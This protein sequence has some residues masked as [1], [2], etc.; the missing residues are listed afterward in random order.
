MLIQ[1]RIQENAALVEAALDSF[2]TA[3]ADTT[4]YRAMAYSTMCGGKRIRFWFWSFAV[5]LAERLKR[6]CH[7]HVR[8]R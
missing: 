7:M 8:W 3:Q 2:F 4:L 6:L 5:C 1:K